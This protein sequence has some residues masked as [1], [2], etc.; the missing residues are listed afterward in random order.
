MSARLEGKVALVTG[1]SKG[2][3]KAISI[4][5]AKEGATVAMAARNGQELSEAAKEVAAAGGSALGIPGD[6]GDDRFVEALFN[7]IAGRHGKLDILVNN[8]GIVDG[9]GD[10]ADLSPA[11][12]REV[13]NV[14]VVA[15]FHCMQQAIRLMRENGDSGK[16][17]NIGSVRSHWTERGEP[18]AYNASKFAV[19]GLSET[20]A[21]LLI[22]G[23]S[24]IT[25][26]M[27]CRE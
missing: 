18:G 1:A 8:A 2:I 10:I 4:L 17:V 19:R 7:Q 15:V 24:K 12:F 22:E 16:I 3:G 13:M 11:K 6:I 25:V 20:V 5:L 26:G 9:G 14:N 27:V 21:R 23:K